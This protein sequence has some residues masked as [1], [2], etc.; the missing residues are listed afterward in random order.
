METKC[1]QGYG[2]SHFGYK[3]HIN[4]DRLYN[5]VLS[6]EVTDASVHDSQVIANILDTDNTTSSVW[7][8]RWFGALASF[9]PKSGL[10]LKT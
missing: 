10:A 9:V 2:K 3:N 6:Y 8:D 7:A 1:F 4:I 5:R